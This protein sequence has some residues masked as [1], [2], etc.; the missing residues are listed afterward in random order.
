MP[1]Q[2]GESYEASYHVNDGAGEYTPDED[3]QPDG[4]ILLSTDGDLK[5]SYPTTSR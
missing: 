1:P 2:R 5:Y 4:N 3:T